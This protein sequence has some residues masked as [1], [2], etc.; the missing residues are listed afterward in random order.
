M[1]KRDAYFAAGYKGGGKSSI[2]SAIST[3]C[4]HER[5]QQYRVWLA[6]RDFDPKDGETPADWALAQ[7]RNL[8]LTVKSDQAKVRALELYGRAVGQDWGG[9]TRPAM[10]KVPA[11]H[12]VAR[13][14]EAL[15]R[16]VAEVAAKKLGVSLPTMIDGK[17]CEVEEQPR[18]E[19]VQ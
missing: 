11:E 5:V 15:G 16:P 14:A 10:E 7:M 2:N 3:L 9:D 8:A 18:S 6:N 4:T 13:V 1:S 17:S 19:S 12:L